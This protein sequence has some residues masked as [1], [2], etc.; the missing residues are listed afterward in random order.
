MQQLVLHQFFMGDVED[1][2]LYAAEPIYKWQQTPAGKWCM[3]HAS[4]LHFNTGL[5]PSSYGYKITIV[6][7]LE[8]KLATEFL[9]RW[10]K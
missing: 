10:N 1:P 4:D 8:D 3:E 2:E 9:L 7:N 5:D 6:G